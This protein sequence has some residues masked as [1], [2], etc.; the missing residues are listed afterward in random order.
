MTLFIMSISKIIV[1]VIAISGHL[2]RQI[3]R[4]YDRIVQRFVKIFTSLDHQG[5]KAINLRGLWQE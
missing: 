3:L 5:V 4:T 2:K 1:S